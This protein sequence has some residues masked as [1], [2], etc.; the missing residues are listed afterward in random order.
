MCC[1]TKL[2]TSIPFIGD[3]LESSSQDPASKINET[4][5]FPVLITAL[6][7]IVISVILVASFILII[8]AGVMWSTGD[9]KGGKDMIVK[10]AI[11]LAILGAS[12]VILRLVNP[13]FFG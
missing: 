11:G 8:V 2:S 1:G 9:A 10:V 6:V 12:G 3:C 13:N 7:K 5:A 4:T